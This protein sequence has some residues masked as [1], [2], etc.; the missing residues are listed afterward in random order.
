MERLALLRSGNQVDAED[1]SFIQE[2][3]PPNDIEL[4]VHAVLGRDNFDLPEDKLD[5]DDLN[6]E[7]I[8][9]AL[10]KNNGNQTRTAQYLGISRRVLQG[11][12]KKMGLTQSPMGTSL[13]K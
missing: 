3:I 2:L 5:I 1:L 7:I 9:M 13:T 6:R 12:L 4:N 8:K 11:R 10:E